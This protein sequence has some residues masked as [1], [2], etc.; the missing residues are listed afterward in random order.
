MKRSRGLARNLMPLV[1]DT[2]LRRH[3][4]W[5]GSGRIKEFRQESNATSG[6]YCTLRRHCSW[7]GSGR[8]STSAFLNTDRSGWSS[9]SSKTWYGNIIDTTCRHPTTLSIGFYWIF[10]GWSWSRFEV[11]AHHRCYK[12]QNWS[13]FEF[14]S[15]FLFNL[16]I[17]TRFSAQ[18][19]EF[20][21]FLIPSKRLTLDTFFR[22]T[23]LRNI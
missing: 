3:C 18:V 22:K 6:R 12:Q 4:S 17:L 11:K 9:Q 8:I 13:T 19:F 1:A 10:L 2:T 14:E 15:T 5:S 21:Y 7:S 16:R 23:K 20:F